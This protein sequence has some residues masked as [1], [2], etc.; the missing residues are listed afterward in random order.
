[1]C[2]N[3]CQCYLSCVPV[4]G[5][6]GKIIQGCIVSISGELLEGEVHTKAVS[7]AGTKHTTCV[8]LPSAHSHPEANLQMQKE[9]TEVH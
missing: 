6:D 3:S 9:G 8:H 5:E 2:S 7:A 4:S 1:M